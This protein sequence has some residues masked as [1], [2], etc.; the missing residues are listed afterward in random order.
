M[1]LI[2]KMSPEYA[3]YLF[4]ES[5][6]MGH[7]EYIAFPADETEL[8]D[9]VR[10][11]ADHQVPLTAQGAL[12]GLAGGASPDGGLILNLQRMNRILGLRRTDDGLF[13]LRSSRAFALPSFAVRCCRKPSMSAAGISSPWIRSGISAPAS[14]SSRQIPPNPQPA[15]A[16]WPPAMPAEPGASCTAVPA[17]TF[18]ASVSSL[19]TAGRRNWSADGTGLPDVKSACE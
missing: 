9:V 15:S 6:T 1:T 2:R 17:R 18:A 16:A 11:C 14:F 19:R 7:A 3:D 4:D 13:C 10:W 8:A 12:T 5:R